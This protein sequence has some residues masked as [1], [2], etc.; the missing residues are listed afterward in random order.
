M[1]RGRGEGHGD[2]G[3]GTGTR[4]GARAHS[5]EL[6]TVHIPWRSSPAHVDAVTGL[7]SDVTPELRPEGG[8]VQSRAFEGKDLLLK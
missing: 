4:G 2:A 5:T 7:G 6:C 3:R 8:T 1:A